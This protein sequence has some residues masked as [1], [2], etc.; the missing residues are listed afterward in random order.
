MRMP[1]LG[2]SPAWSRYAFT[3]MHR[4]PRMVP[5]AVAGSHSTGVMTGQDVS[6]YVRSHNQTECLVARGGILAMRPF[7]IHCSSKALNGVPRR[8][9]HIEHADWIQLAVA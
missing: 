4:P 2:P 1:R 8:V 3:R 9:L 5:C 7:L 6:D